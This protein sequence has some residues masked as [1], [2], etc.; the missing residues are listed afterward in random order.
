MY[1]S[2]PERS[3]RTVIAITGVVFGLT[4]SSSSTGAQQFV[5]PTALQRFLADRMGPVLDVRSSGDCS[6]AVALRRSAVRIP[7]DGYG[8]SGDARTMA[9]DAFLERVAKSAQLAKARL[10][11]S[12]ILIVCCSGGRSEQAAKFLTGRSYR[13]ATLVD[14]L[15][16]QQIPKRAMKQ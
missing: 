3:M 11:G 10:N 7:Y 1:F 9:D 13:T 14:G 12:I 16:S 15:T 2:T 4:T 5:Q 8:T 6:D